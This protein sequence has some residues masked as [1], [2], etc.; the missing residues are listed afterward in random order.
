M[1][2]RASSIDGVRT[3]SDLAAF[4]G[5]SASA[6]ELGIIPPAHLLASFVPLRK[7]TQMCFSVGKPSP[8]SAMD[9][10]YASI[11]NTPVVVAGSSPTEDS[12]CLL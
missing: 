2:A 11:S 6:T 12:M 8:L 1:I 7:T 9:L 10:E 4:F 5:R 3:G